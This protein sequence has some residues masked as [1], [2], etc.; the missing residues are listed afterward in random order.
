MKNQKAFPGVGGFPCL[1]PRDQ[2]PDGVY[3]LNSARSCLHQFLKAAKPEI[4]YFPR[5]V[6]PSF[7]SYANRLDIKFE[8]YSID[9]HFLPLVSDLSVA[10]TNSLIVYVNYFGICSAQVEYVINKFG[11]Q[12]VIIDN[13]QSYSFEKENSLATIYSPRKFF[14]L[15]DGGILFSDLKVDLCAEFSSINLNYF[16]EKI[17]GHHD[18]AYASFKTSENELAAMG[19]LALGEYSLRLLESFLSD[20]HLLTM[21]ETFF[22]ELDELF[23]SK[24]LIKYAFD[25]KNKN[26]PLC[27]PLQTT[28]AIPASKLVEKKVF[29]AV[30]WPTLNDSELNNFELKLKNQ[31]IFLPLSNIRDR[32]DFEFLIETMSDLLSDQI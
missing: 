9:E 4:V 2:Y 7:L 14:P 27:Y 16:E 1:A 6:C 25:S 3:Y 24:N 18:I 12:R 15:S 28:V 19:P 22:R 30:Y 11:R 26:F 20:K 29:S 32:G 21:R 23:G 8:F 10:N 5:F 13:S 31:T 17:R